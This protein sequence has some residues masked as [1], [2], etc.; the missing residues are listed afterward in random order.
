MRMGLL[1]SASPPRPPPPSASQQHHRLQQQQ[2]QQ[3]QQQGGGGRRSFSSEANFGLTST[4]TS[5]SINAA[6]PSPPHILST[7]QRS[8]NKPS[9]NNGHNCGN[10]NHS[11]AKILSSTHTVP[12]AGFASGLSLPS[13]PQ[14]QSSLEPSTTG[15]LA[16]SP[17]PRPAIPDPTTA[18][19]RRPATVRSTKTRTTFA[20]VD[21]EADNFNSTSPHT[22]QDSADSMDDAGLVA[23]RYAVSAALRMGDGS[24]LAATHPAFVRSGTLSS[25]PIRRS[26]GNGMSSDAVAEQPRPMSKQIAALYRI[27]QEGTCQRTGLPEDLALAANQPMVLA[28]TLAKTIRS[29]QILCSSEV[30]TRRNAS[31]WSLV[32]LVTRGG[33][34][35]TSS[36][37]SEYAAKMD[38]LLDRGASAD[39]LTA[40][41]NLV[42][43]SRIGH[44]RLVALIL[45]HVATLPTFSAESFILPSIS[46]CLSSSQ[47][48]GTLFLLLAHPTAA[49]TELPSS[50]IVS[51][52]RKAVHATLSSSDIGKD[53]VRTLNLLLSF[54]SAPGITSQAVGLEHLLTAAQQGQNQL[55]EW[56]LAQGSTKL[57]GDSAVPV[58]I[59]GDE[60]SLWKRL[61]QSF[62]LPRRNSTMSRPSSRT[63]RTVQLTP[64]S[65]TLRNSPT[66]EDGVLPAELNRLEAI[67]IAI[68]RSV[69]QGYQECVRI[70]CQSW[71]IA[72]STTCSCSKKSIDSC[73]LTLQ[74]CRD[75]ASSRDDSIIC[76][77]L[78]S[79]L[80]SSEI[81]ARKPSS[82][83]SFFH[84]IFSPDKK[85]KVAPQSDYHFHPRVKERCTNLGK[86]PTDQLSAYRNAVESY[87]S[88]LPNIYD[89]VE[90]LDLPQVKPPSTS[91]A[92]A[93]MSIATRSEGDTQS[94]V[95]SVVLPSRVGA[96]TGMLDSIPDDSGPMLSVMDDRSE[97]RSGEVTAV[98]GESP[99]SQASVISS[100]SPTPS[101][102]G[103]HVP[104]HSTVPL[105]SD[106]NAQSGEN[107]SFSSS[108]IEQENA[109]TSAHA[110]LIQNKTSLP[111]LPHAPD[112]SPAS[113]LS[114]ISELKK[115]INREIVATSTFED[116]P[117]P[118][119]TSAPQL[120]ASSSYLFDLD[121]ESEEESDGDVALKPEASPRYAV[122]DQSESLLSKLPEE[123]YF[124]C[125]LLLEEP[126]LFHL[127]STCREY[128]ALR[129]YPDFLAEYY[130]SRYDTPRAV[131]IFLGRRFLGFSGTRVALVESVL[132]TPPKSLPTPLLSIEAYIPQCLALDDNDS[133]AYL[134]RRS[135]SVPQSFLAR[136]PSAVLSHCLVRAV[137]SGS[138]RCVEVLLK[139]GAEADQDGVSLLTVAAGKGFGLA[140]EALLE[141]GADAKQDDSAALRAAAGSDH[142]DAARIVA[143]L[144]V[145][146]ADITARAQEPLRKASAVGNPDV[147]AVVSAVIGSLAVSG[148]KGWEARSALKVMF[149]VLCRESHGEALTRVLKEKSTWSWDG[150]ADTILKPLL[151]RAVL[152]GDVDIVRGFSYSGDCWRELIKG[153]E[154][155]LLVQLAA[156]FSDDSSTSIEA[157]G[158]STSFSGVG[159]SAPRPVRSRRESA[160]PGIEPA[161]FLRPGAQNRKSHLPHRSVSAD[162]EASSDVYSTSAAMVEAM[163]AGVANHS[164]KFRATPSIHVI[165]AWEFLRNA[166]CPALHAIKNAV[167]VQAA[168]RG[169]DTVLDA[170]LSTL[171]PDVMGPAGAGALLA[172]VTKGH[173]KIVARLISAGVDADA[174]SA[175]MYK[176]AREKG[177]KQVLKYL[178]MT[179]EIKVRRSVALGNKTS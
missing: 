42:F 102:R 100:S 104:V 25:G 116:A 29:V 18:S 51:W 8:P 23:L 88:N 6:H 91:S 54:V 98:E 76:E 78:S 75:I 89:L 49:P 126:D 65:A 90:Q 177:Q 61:R 149:E 86:I 134:L 143:R 71:F 9:A 169:N 159:V 47:D 105:N 87:F 13:S 73:R 144:L 79:V 162:D 179:R 37:S 152:D 74:V 34:A 63:S 57:V 95:E 119:K 81:L 10:S 113:L 38:Y 31:S 96:V 142:A 136:P 170:I 129:K 122:M 176:I 33:A 69:I 148:A 12:A 56:I 130:V 35:S 82:R 48:L 128:S 106:S 115:E 5:T 53:P 155:K 2:Q 108:P 164:A 120:S 66:E 135:F 11:S 165:D 173:V 112:A 147:L 150:C 153:A 45:D 154:G 17:S 161:A 27:L 175:A 157:N 137:E 7:H 52:I 39:D 21:L 28:R 30:D 92:E 43:A 140:V 44:T 64:T 85:R 4:G 15:L 124:Q 94:A 117:S 68:Y 24:S 41:E 70:L 123:V 101:I 60:A 141:H 32:E 22:G 174:N 132:S 158:Q 127:T 55:L 139:F 14:S 138:C 178:K 80:D 67:T 172:A 77:L 145:A 84:K 103:A 93:L 131:E 133:L 160:I 109:S 118:S 58:E 26:S 3:Q 99:N 36:L 72:A 83:Q 40:P 97:A 121:E 156:K 19:A 166:E 125:L 111:P 1:A 16:I 20:S 46:A 110:L 59:S 114:T 146:G 171:Q 50:W 62:D 163:I 107:A 151:R 167:L 168:W